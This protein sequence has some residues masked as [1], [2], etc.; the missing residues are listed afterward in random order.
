MLQQLSFWKSL[1]SDFGRVGAVMPSSRYLAREMASV[2]SKVSNTGVIEVGAGT[3]AITDHLLRVGEAAND[4]EQ[5][6]GDSIP[7]SQLLLVERCELM[8]DFLRKKY[9]SKHTKVLCM[10]VQSLDASRLPFQPDLIVSSVPFFSL[11]PHDRESIMRK[12]IELLPVGGHV[13]Q[14]TYNLN[15]SF[16]KRFEGL[17]LV[18]RKTVLR[19]VPPAHVLL[20]RRV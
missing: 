6:A 8:S 7:G 16:F 9:A 20:L 4:D 14:Y 11:P 18:S 15:V 3:G 10:D 5:D 2:A 13:L 17:K 19:N 12:Y 1:T